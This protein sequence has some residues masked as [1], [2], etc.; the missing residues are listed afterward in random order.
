MDFRGCK[1]RPS[2]N[3]SQGNKK[4]TRKEF[5][6][7]NECLKRVLEEDSPGKLD[8]SIEDKEM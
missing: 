1:R 7:P 2:W 3:S 4:K 5:L 8:K 6:S